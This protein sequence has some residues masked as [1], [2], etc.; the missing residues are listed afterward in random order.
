VASEQDG[1]GN[2]ASGG[3][4]RRGCYERGGCADMPCLKRRSNTT[5]A[6]GGDQPCHRNMSMNVTA[7]GFAC[8]VKAQSC[9][10][11]IG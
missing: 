2:E 6:I 1:G 8:G 11:N 10:T 4:G 7:I 3:G 5:K 9:G